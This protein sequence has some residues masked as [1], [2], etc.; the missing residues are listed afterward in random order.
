MKHSTSKHERSLVDPKDL[1]LPE[2]LRDTVTTFTEPHE[3]LIYLASSLAVLAGCMPNVQGL[4]K[5]GR[6]YSPTHF[7]CVVAR[8][9][10][11]KS[12]INWARKLGQ[13]VHKKIIKSSE[14][15]SFGGEESVAEQH[16]GLF[17][18]TDAS[19]A[20]FI[21][22]LDANGGR[23][24]MIA[25]EIDTL[26]GSFGQEWGKF[27]DKLRMAAEHEPIET[28]RVDDIVSVDRPELSLVL[29]G[30]PNQARE[31]FTSPE[32]GLYSRFGLLV[33]EAPRTWDRGGPSPEDEDRRATV[34]QAAAR[35]KALYQ[36]LQQR[37]S[38][39]R[40]TMNESQW[41]SLDSLFETRLRDLAQHSAPAEL[42]SCVKRAGVTAFRL[43]MT[44]S[45]LRAFEEGEALDSIQTVSPTGEEM[46]AALRLADMYLENALHFA[47]GLPKSISP[48]V[49]SKGMTYE[50]FYGLLP[51]HFQRK[52]A[53]AIGE[54][55]SPELSESTVDRYL[56]KLSESGRLTKLSHGKYTKP[57]GEAPAGAAHERAEG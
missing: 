39:L 22:A 47:E 19:A 5:Q 2:V 3:R 32:D 55:M 44:L 16:H 46:E 36:R 38:P 41:D 30:T 49:S 42:D 18:T 8:S 15:I 45:V 25:T 31:L 37:E 12:A 10:S 11:G 35:V 29:S 33:Y 23:G 17:L 27:S 20:A 9:A 57:N 52:K 6:R 21:R 28:L 4:Y 1:P 53:V 14:G 48:Q 43:A 54:S 24:V 51:S 26:L 40:F 34:K 13:E 56:K 7:L 50:V